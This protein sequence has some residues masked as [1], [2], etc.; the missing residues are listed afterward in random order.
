MQILRHL[1]S[2]VH[3][4]GENPHSHRDVRDLFGWAGGSMLAPFTVKRVPHKG[5]GCVATGPLPAG[6]LLGVYGHSY[7]CLACL[8]YCISIFVLILVFV[9]FTFPKRKKPKS[10]HSATS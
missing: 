6:T 4:F 2:S 9:G 10:T 5:L 3:V 8:V 7:S 1:P